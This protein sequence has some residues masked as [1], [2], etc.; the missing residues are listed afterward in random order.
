MKKNI[1]INTVNGFGDEWERFNQS[2]LKDDEKRELFNYYFNIFP[3]ENI[4]SESIGFDAGCGS[5]R[6]ASLVAPKVKTL[7][8]V[9]PS[10]AINVAKFNL[11]NFDNCIFLNQSI[12]EFSNNYT[13]F[14]FGY[15]LGVLHHIPDTKSALQNCV[16]VLKPGA[17]FLLYLYYSF[18][19]KPTWYFYMWKLSD[20]L[21]KL[22]SILPYNLRYIVSQIIAF[23]IYLP[24]AK[25][26]NLLSKLGLNVSNFPLSAY[27][28]TSIYTIRTDALDRFGTRLEQRF[29]KKEIYN[30]MTD[31]GLVDIKFSESIPYWCAVGIKKL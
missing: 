7:Y 16:N 27:Q 10:S 12:D 3:W 14:D 29:S 19:N 26:A 6:W 11:K 23:L 30:L 22:I 20:Y 17:P 21:R 4:N 18:D 31:V 25:T 24:F 13:N 15:S 2:N 8:C 9:D 1:D 5:G 28:N